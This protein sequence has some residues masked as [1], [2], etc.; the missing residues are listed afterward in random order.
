[1]CKR[2]LESFP[3]EVVRQVV[4]KV[5]RRVVRRLVSKVVSRWTSL[6]TTRRT[7]QRTSFDRRSSRFRGEELAPPPPANQGEIR[8]EAASDPSLPTTWIEGSE[9]ACSSLGMVGGGVASWEKGFGN[10]EK[11]NC[12]VG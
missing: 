7:R 2:C 8:G 6:R 12:E 5:V 1:M 11:K 4:H 3:T 10:S 9:A